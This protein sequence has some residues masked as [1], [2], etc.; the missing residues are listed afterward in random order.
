MLVHQKMIKRVLEEINHI[1]FKKIHI[2]KELEKKLN[3]LHQ[4]HGF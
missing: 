2:T 3:T 1:G 4:N